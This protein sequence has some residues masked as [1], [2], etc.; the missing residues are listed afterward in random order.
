MTNITDF[1]WSENPGTRKAWCYN[2]ALMH[3]GIFLH[4]YRWLLQGEND[5]LISISINSSTRNIFW[6][7]NEGFE[8]HSFTEL[9]NFLQERAKIFPT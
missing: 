3:R 6:L 8:F 1:L 5:L 9:L 4:Q 7:R 2:L